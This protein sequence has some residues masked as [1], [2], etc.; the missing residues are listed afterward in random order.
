M[1]YVKIAPPPPLCQQTSLKVEVLSSPFLKI[2]LV[3]QPPIRPAEKGGGG[4]AYTMN[5]N[6]SI[7]SFLTDSKTWVGKCE[8]S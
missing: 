3:A 7:V 4:G 1:F 6:F 8:S 2:W 5:S